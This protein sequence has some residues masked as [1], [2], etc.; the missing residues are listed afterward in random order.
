[1]DSVRSWHPMSHIVHTEYVDFF[2]DNKDSMSGLRSM[3]E[4]PEP[5]Y[6]MFRVED[7]YCKGFFKDF[8]GIK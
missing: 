8:K 5:P 4:L 2:F 6:K 3:H 1:M 7:G